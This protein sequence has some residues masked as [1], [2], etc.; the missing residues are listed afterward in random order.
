MMGMFRLTE[1]EKLLVLEFFTLRETAKG[2][3]L[4]RRHFDS[5]LVPMEKGDAII[6]RLAGLRDKEARF[7][8][9]VHARPKTSRITR[10]GPDSYVGRSEV[11]ADDGKVSVIEATW[12]R[13]PPGR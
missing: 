9:P 7:E 3:E 2:L 13:T 8:N 1:G 12:Q 6:L 10:T 5:A 11:I 4:R